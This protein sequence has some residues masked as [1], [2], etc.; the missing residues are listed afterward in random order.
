VRIAIE[1][2][3]WINRRGYGRFTREVTRAL[4][5]LDG[6]HQWSL[7]LDKGAARAA[8]LPET[9]R[10]VVPTGEAVVDAA[11]AE[12]ARSVRDLWRMSRA[13]SSPDFDAVIF[14]TVY[15][16]VPVLS[17]ARVMVIYHDAMPEAMPRLV[18]GTR[19]AEMLWRAKSL[20][21]CWR[22][23]VLA[24]VSDASA[25]A[26]RAHLPVGRRP[27]VVLTEGWS[28]IFTAVADSGDAAVVEQVVPRG[29]RFVLSVGTASPHKRMAEL[30]RA[31]GEIASRPENLD[32]ALVMVG[33]A[34]KSRFASARG[35]VQ[36]AVESIG[37]A[38]ER[39]VRTDYLPDSALAALYRT[40]ACVA[41]PS[42]AEG[43]G[44]PAL[45]AMA[46]GCPI[47]ASDTPALKEVCGPAAEYFSDLADLGPTLGRLVNDP[48][49]LGALRRAGRE[50]LALYGW[51]EAARRLL[52]A[53]D[54]RP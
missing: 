31:F 30:V 23:N 5:K 22:A 44:L 24:T 34:R 20:M 4:L 35:K 38:G 10:I 27:L 37:P 39:V 47:L 29:C 21:A 26:I 51:D 46:S 54:G 50:R 16:F 41:V 15:S 40:A 25:A 7:V 3:T 49:R 43:F 13:L 28:P 9:R 12:G 42:L 19:R 53:L 6:G 8:D 18:L 14:P 48:A 45:E 17:R 11:S 2:S 33:A 36:A 1:A 52:K 32:L